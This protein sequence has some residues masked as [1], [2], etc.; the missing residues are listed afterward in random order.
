M[1]MTTRRCWWRFWTFW[2]TINIQKMSP[3]STNRQ[4]QVTNINVMH[5]LRS[6]WKNLSQKNFVWLSKILIFVYP[7]VRWCSFIMDRS[8]VKKSD[9][10]KMKNEI[11]SDSS[12]KLRSI[13][14][15]VANFHRR[16]SPKSHFRAYM[17][18]NW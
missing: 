5:F 17:I 4:F 16:Q 7:L 6:C 9:I 8:S 1:L 18:G 3:T 11:N 15:L 10:I 2:S 13:F 12:G 14:H